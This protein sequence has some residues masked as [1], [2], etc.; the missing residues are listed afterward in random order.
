MKQ[1]KQHYHNL[2]IG[3]GKGG[4]TLAAYLARQGEEVAVVER[5]EMMYGGTCINVACIPSKSLITSAEKGIQYGDAFKTKNAL[6]SLLRKKNYDALEEHPLITVI[7]GTASFLELAH[8]VRIV[9][10]D[11][12]DDVIVTAERIFINTG[13]EPFMPD[14][15]GL[16]TSKR[17][18]TSASLMDQSG[19]P[20]TLIIVGGGFIGLEFADMYAKFGAQVTILDHKKEFLPKEDNDVADEIYRIL[21]EKNI[22]IVTGVS[23][24]RIEDSAQGTVVQFEKID[25]TTGKIEGE[26]I[27]IAAGRKANVG[28]LNLPAA[29][30]KTDERGF[31]MVDE[32]LRTNVNSIW[33]IG[34]VNGGPQFT[35][36][37]LDDFRIIR[38]QLFGGDYTSVEKRK[39]T[40][41]SVFITPPLAHIGLR[42]RQA[43]EKGYQIK[44]AKLTAA[45]IPRAR[46]MNETRG[47]LKS[48]I[49]A[50]TNR[51]L[52]C[53]LL[54]AEATEMINTI[55]VA[56]NEG[57]D[58]RIVRDTIFTHPS[59]TE[60]FNDLYA[61]I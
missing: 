45:A 3:F 50:D 44:V 26:A 55:Q 58:Y 48:V 61:S 1:V 10:K 11:S 14:I 36:I 52:G 13:T 8:H 40:A 33:A 53:T 17:V 5:S 25:G 19:L 21:T 4:K 2:I 29:G 9:L 37:S 51:I 60:A 43:K 28:G 30:I 12:G 22:K 6:T 49:D 35:Y 39:A 23:V 42:E 27:L 20:K 56:I 7:T 32:G 34:D 59:M 54:C 31:V 24:Q 38:D 16:K 46:I 57:L 18:F 47:I 15:A 41:T